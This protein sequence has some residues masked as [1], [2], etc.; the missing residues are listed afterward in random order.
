MRLSSL[1]TICERLS[2]LKEPGGGL[3]FGLLRVVLGRGVP[4]FIEDLGCGEGG[5]SVR[6]DLGESVAV[7]M[8]MISCSC[9]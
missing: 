8:L 4:G 2:E 1:S 7:A 3:L 6:D 5:T 9:S